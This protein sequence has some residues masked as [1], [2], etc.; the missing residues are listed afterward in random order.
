MLVQ[1][2]PLADAHISVMCTVFSGR[3]A[4]HLDGIVRN[5]GMLR[6][7]LWVDEAIPER[8]RRGKRVGGER[9]WGEDRAEKGRERERERERAM[10]GGGGR[11]GGEE[12]DGEAER[13]LK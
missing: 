6:C 4:S 13:T 2:F 9:G 1:T 8:N 5:G 11:E 7:R 12:R 3:I 10:G